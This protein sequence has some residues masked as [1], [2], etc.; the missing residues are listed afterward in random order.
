LPSDEEERFIAAPERREVITLAR[1]YDHYLAR[2]GNRSLPER[3][4]A[5]FD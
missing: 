2:G 3:V 5:L 1:A 4:L